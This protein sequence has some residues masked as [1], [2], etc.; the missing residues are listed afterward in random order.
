MKTRTLILALLM[1][2]SLFLVACGGATSN[3]PQLEEIDLSSLPDTV[4]VQTVAAIKDNPGVYLLDVREP[5]E[6]ADGHI[7]G[8]TLMPMGEVADRMSEIPKD[9]QVIVTCRSGNR[10]GQITD[11]LREQGFTNVHNM[12]GGIVAWEAA[13]FDV[14][15]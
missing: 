5:D 8:I 14:Q 4:D 1:L 11:F 2:A 6:Y 3:A 7:P 12:E 10:S 15:Q 9:K 13:G